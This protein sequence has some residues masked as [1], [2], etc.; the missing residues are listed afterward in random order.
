M[1]ITTH[2]SKRYECDRCGEKAE[3]PSEVDAVKQGWSHVLVNNNRTT[4]LCPEDATKHSRFL[5]GTRTGV[6]IHF[7]RDEGN[8]WQASW[9]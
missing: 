1:G 4:I 8:R 9:R 6:G 2:E 5:E 3:Y 7:N